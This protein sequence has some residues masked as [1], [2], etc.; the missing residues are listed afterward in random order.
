[1]EN[2]VVSLPNCAQDIDV[3]DVKQVLRYTQSLRMRAVDLMTAD[4]KSIPDDIAAL[5]S[6]LKDVDS[7]ALT[8]RKL[9]IDEKTGTASK[10]LLETFDRLERLATG[11]NRSKDITPGREVSW[12]VDLP[13]PILV[14]GEDRQNEQILSASEFLPAEQ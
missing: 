13:D 8:S 1:M 3:D 7:T 5:Q 12:M 14:P 11:G 4:G 9:D 2:E 10:A 6:L